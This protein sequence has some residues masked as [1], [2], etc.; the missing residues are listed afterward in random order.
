MRKLIPVIL[1]LIGLAAG[2]AAGYFLRPSAS[3]ETG[4]ESH[5]EA[6]A[7][8]PKHGA[9]P[10]EGEKAEA[11]EGEATSEYV[12]LNNQFVVPVI[13]EGKVTALVVLSLSLEVT[14]GS[15]E[16]VY[17]A[18]PKI[19][20]ALLQVLFDH[21]NAGGFDGAFTDTANM[22]DLRR[23]LLEAAQSVLGEIVAHVLVSDIVRQDAV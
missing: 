1:A 22:E 13:R 8:A 16:K 12:K 17:A 20:D 11:G 23:A 6:A 14:V 3:A 18:E 15:T 9:A 19:R 7:E 5:A 4:G 21:A 2:G 10:K